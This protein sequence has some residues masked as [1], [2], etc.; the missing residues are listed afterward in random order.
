MFKQE[1]DKEKLKNIRLLVLDVDGVLTD[2]SIILN[3][4][5]V[6]SK[7]FN[8]HDGHGIKLW[9][10]AGHQ[11]AILSGRAV[12]VT[13]LRAAQLDIQHVYQGC[14]EKL[15][16]FK[17]MLETLNISPEQV[18]WVGDD[19]VD[20]PVARQAGFSAA[21][22]NAVDELKLCADYV[23]KRQGGGGAVRE[24]VKLILEHQ[25]KWQKLMDR[26]LG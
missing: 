22:D 16:A 17:E 18:A 1:Y 7:A 14:K 20:I 25:D 26:Y 9:H 24:I 10:R 15:P 6:E 23:S 21:V 4:Y 13:N 5:G 19:V 3:D 2:G 12:N 8:V 11:S